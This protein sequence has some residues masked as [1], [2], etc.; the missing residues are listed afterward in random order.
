M[1]KDQLHSG[2]QIKNSEILEHAEEKARLLQE[3]VD[4]LSLQKEE[5]ETMQGD[6]MSQKEDGER[7]IQNVLSSKD[8][9][10]DALSQKNSQLKEDMKEFKSTIEVQKKILEEIQKLKENPRSASNAPELDN[11]RLE[12]DRL[13]DENAKLRSEMPMGGNAGEG[14]ESGQNLVKYL[15]SKIYHFEKTV[16]RLEKERSSLTVRATMAEE[17]LKVLQ[18]HTQQSSVSY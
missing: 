4:Q 10:I 12:R 11:L 15:R 14:G 3:Q 16:E 1:L 6:M 8:Q 13:L 7:T 2:G 9:E 5:L 18:S 17:Q